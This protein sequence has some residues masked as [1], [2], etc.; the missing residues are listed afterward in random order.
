MPICSSHHR[1]RADASGDEELLQRIHAFAADAQAARQLVTRLRRLLPDRLRELTR[2]LRLV[3]KA[4]GE[5][6]AH[7]ERLALTDPR[8][9]TFVA[10]LMEMTGRAAA[11]RVEYETHVMLHQARRSA[12]VPN[13]GR[14]GG[15]A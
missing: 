11:A 3:A 14:C 2:E 8:Y 5:G 6:A 13:A 9:D 12:R 15:R 1:K 4:A 10:E 7:A